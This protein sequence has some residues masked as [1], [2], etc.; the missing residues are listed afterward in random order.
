M[1]AKVWSAATLGIDAV[2]ITVEVDAVEHGQPKFIMVGLPD[3]AVREAYS[4][5]RSAL[6][7]CGFWWPARRVTVNPSPAPAT[8]NDAA[9][10]PSGRALGVDQL[11]AL[12]R[13]LKGQ[14][15]V[16]PTT[17]ATIAEPP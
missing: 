16:E 11:R 14:K 5:V 12:V 4:R 15:A 8:P 10:V 7:N 17:S 6:H 13:H 9:P 1:L 2:R 3:L